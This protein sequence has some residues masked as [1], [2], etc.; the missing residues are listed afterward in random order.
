[1]TDA[2]ARKPN[3]TGA[4]PQEPGPRVSVSAHDEGGPAG[5]LPTTA[6]G[7][8]VNL[9]LAKAAA[10]LLFV[11]ALAAGFHYAAFRPSFRGSLDHADARSVRGWVLDKAEPGRRVEVQLYL[12]GRLAASGE[13][14]EPRPDVAAE[15]YAPDERHGFVF[16]LGPQPPGEHEARVYAV[17]ASAGGRRRT[18][19]QIGHAMKFVVR[20][21]Q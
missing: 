18:L 19:Q 14:S 21:R 5:S 3:D 17:H 10:D 8:L 13:A 7:R 20:E 6:R 2:A 11:C 12:D 1:M 9:L 15:G 4:G 16:L